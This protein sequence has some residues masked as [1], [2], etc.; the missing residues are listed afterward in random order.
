MLTKMSVPRIL[1]IIVMRLPLLL[2]P[3][4]FG[5]CLYMEECFV[6]LLLIFLVNEK[7]FACDK[8]CNLKI[9]VSSQEKVN[10]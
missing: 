1:T 4:R 9:L 5:H 3:R 6:S 8:I 2:M 10:V 7:D